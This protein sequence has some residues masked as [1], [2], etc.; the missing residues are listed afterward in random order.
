MKCVIGGAH[1]RGTRGPRGGSKPGTKGCVCERNGAAS[2]WH[3]SA[4]MRVRVASSRC[5]QRRPGAVRGCKMGYETTGAASSAMAVTAALRSCLFLIPR[6]TAAVLQGHTAPGGCSKRRAG[7]VALQVEMELLSRLPS[8]AHSSPS[9]G[10][11]P[12]PTHSIPCKMLP[13]SVS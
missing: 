13:V 7:A 11:A 1:L 2:G 10:P 3:S 8:S 6:R 5:P 12:P 9:T 4:A